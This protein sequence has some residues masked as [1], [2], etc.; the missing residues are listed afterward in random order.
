MQHKNVLLIQKWQE[1]HPNWDKSEQET[2]QY[3]QMVQKMM[4]NVD[5]DKCISEISKMATIPKQNSIASCENKKNE[6][7]M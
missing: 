1:E 2:E 7:I 5:E 6:T 4:D 3:I